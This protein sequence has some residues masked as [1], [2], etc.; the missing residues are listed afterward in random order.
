M[1]YPKPISVGL[2]VALGTI[3][4]ALVAMLAYVLVAGTIP[5]KN[6]QHTREDHPGSYYAGVI[7][8]AAQV[9]LVGFL[10]VCPSR[11]E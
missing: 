2:R 5:V 9:A 10:T 4:L 8:L 3:T 7:V 11:K 6:G 1:R